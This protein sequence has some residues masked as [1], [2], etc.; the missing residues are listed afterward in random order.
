MRIFPDLMNEWYDYNRSIEE[1]LFG[2]ETTPDHCRCIPR[3]LRYC[4]FPTD[5]N[6]AVGGSNNMT[7][8]THN[9]YY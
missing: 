7:T 4:P 3:H 9:K 6:S 8:T 5:N 2:L 1:P